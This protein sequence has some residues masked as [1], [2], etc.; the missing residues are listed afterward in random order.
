[1]MATGASCDF[2]IFMVEDEKNWVT[3]DEAFDRQDFIED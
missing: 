3:K 2:S 1:M